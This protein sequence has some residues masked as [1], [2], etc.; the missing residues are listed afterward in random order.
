[1]PLKTNHK[2]GASYVEIGASEADRRLDNFLLGRL[3]DVPRSRVYRMI[4]SGEV[5]VNSARVSAGYRLR[6][7]DRV[8]VPPHSRGPEAPAPV[9]SAETSRRVQD[10][11]LHEEEGFLVLDKP[12]GLPVHSGTRFRVGLIDALR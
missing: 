3:R 7:G 12:A 8:R 6:P 5:R 11:I 1:M 9:V 2:G 10:A 4:R